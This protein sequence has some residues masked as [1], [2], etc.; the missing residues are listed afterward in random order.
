[1]SDR[2]I[3]IDLNCDMGELPELLADGTEESLMREVSSANIACGAHAG[4]PKSMKNL[5]NLSI[6]YGVAVGAHISYPDRPNFGRK[7]VSM[8]ADD[9]EELTYSQISL[10][11]NIASDSGARLN[12]IKPHGALYHAAQN[13]ELI[14]EA[15]AKAV[16]RLDK[17]LILVEQASSPVLS[18]WSKLG[19]RSIAEAF[20][21][22]RYESD[23]RLR[24]RTLPQAV[25]TD[26]AAA[27]DQ[28]L[29]IV[30]QQTV[31]AYDGSRL[32]LNAQTICI[33]G[34]TPGSLTTAQS[35]RAAL[36][37]AGVNVRPTK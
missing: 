29:R 18:F 10:L 7:Q 2:Q 12:H 34:D 1:M 36:D 6:K 17:N 4:S 35:I 31:V 21:D 5:V 23:G 9:I 19:F 15:I 3:T 11:A 27:A 28:A 32:P 26:P 37:V 8:S 30:K 13:D 20:A 24:S 22:R 14:A 33:H 25:I 16:G